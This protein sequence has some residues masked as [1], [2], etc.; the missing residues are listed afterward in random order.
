MAEGLGRNTGQVIEI[1]A[2]TGAITRGI[3]NAGVPPENLT[4]IE[5]NSRFCERLTEK[6]PRS[7]V[8]NCMAQDIQDYGVQEAA[9][10]ISSLPLLNIPLAAQK[11][12][13]RTIFDVLH[14]NAPM[15]QF[16]YGPHS[17]ISH[18]LCNALNLKVERRGKVLLNMPPATVYVYR[19]TKTH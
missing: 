11:D 1:G 18:E 15:V 13:L 17:P 16:T 14:P 6:F 5:L 8:I 3:L 19:Q 2:G 12:I 4:M 7:R 9:V 10:V